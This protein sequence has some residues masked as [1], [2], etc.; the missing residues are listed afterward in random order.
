MI[1]KLVSPR[2]LWLQN[3]ILRHIY[4]KVFLLFQPFHRYLPSEFVKRANIIK[5]ICCWFQISWKSCK[6][7]IRKKV[8][9]NWQKN[10]VFKFYY[11]VPTFSASNFFVD[12]FCAISRNSN[13][14]SNFALYDIHIKCFSFFV[15]AIFITLKPYLDEMTQKSKKGFYVYVLCFFESHFTSISDL[16]GSFLF[17]KK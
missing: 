11:C 9:K 14:A 10:W 5:Q 12:F 6:K 13:S 7:L 2:P 16:A 1:L 15:L 4:K 3:L 8:T 17:F